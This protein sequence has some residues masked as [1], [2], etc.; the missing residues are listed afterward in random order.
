MKVKTTKAWCKTDAELTVKDCPAARLT[1]Y[2]V[3]GL[4]V[5]GESR[6][7]LRTGGRDSAQEGGLAGYVAHESRRPHPEWSGSD[8]GWSRH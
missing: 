1:D 2:D 8:V 6:R 3:D 4:S 5:A 7:L